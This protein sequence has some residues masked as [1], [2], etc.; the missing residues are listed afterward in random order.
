MSCKQHQ[1][2]NRR[3]N[4][5]DLRGF[6]LFYHSNDVAGQRRLLLTLGSTVR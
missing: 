2:H 6:V 3:L 1:L 4:L 5:Q